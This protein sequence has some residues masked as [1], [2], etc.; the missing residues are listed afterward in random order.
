MH[1][2]RCC[3]AAC[4]VC[5]PPFSSV[6]RLRPTKRACRSTIS[7]RRSARPRRATRLTTRCRRRA[8]I[9]NQPGADLPPF[10][11][12]GAGLIPVAL[13]FPQL[14][15]TFG[16]GACLEITPT[17]TGGGRKNVSLLGNPFRAIVVS[18]CPECP[19]GNIDIR[20]LGGDGRWQVTWRA[21]DCPV[22]NDIISYLFN[23]TNALSFQIQPRGFRQP[24]ARFDGFINGTWVPFYKSLRAD[25]W[26]FR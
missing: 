15:G 14:D 5:A 11:S 18:G 2:V 10:P 23:T 9:G 17:G 1:H 6:R 16:C 25:N 3:C 22:G 13:N 21:I 20:D 26:F 4:C 12:W 8:C 19:S 7:R 24:V